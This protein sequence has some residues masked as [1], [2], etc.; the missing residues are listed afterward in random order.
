MGGGVFIADSRLFF[1]QELAALLRECDVN[2]FLTGN[3]RDEEESIKCRYDIEWN[4]SSIFSLQSL[5]LQLKNMSS[6][7]EQAVIPFDSLSY[8]NLY[9][10]SSSIFDI[11]SVL[12]EL[13]TANIALVR[14]LK[15]YFEDKGS[16]R[17]IF[18]YRGA[19]IPTEN[20]NV[21]AASGAF[22]KMAE[23]TVASILKDEK[24]GIQ[25]L[26]VKLEEKCEDGSTQWLVNQMKQ[27]SFAKMQG[28]WI[29]AGQKSIFGKY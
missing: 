29:K 24:I 9:P 3:K 25:T 6:Q 22:I 19:S 16:G 4:R 23:E 12:T 21:M 26:L 20:T 7:V 27:P 1:S 11:D 5:A 10:A 14:I 15:D 17:L 18:V 13:I 2:V 28:K 8:L